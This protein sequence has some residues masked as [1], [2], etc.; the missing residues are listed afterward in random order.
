VKDDV[1]VIAGCWRPTEKEATVS[2]FLPLCFAVLTNV[3]HGSQRKFTP[4]ISQRAELRNAISTT[5]SQM[6]KNGR[7]SGRRGGMRQR[8]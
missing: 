7:W 2:F 6:R 8:G 4:T 3:Q 1:S 5:A